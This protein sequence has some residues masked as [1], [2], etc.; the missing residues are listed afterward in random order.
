MK[1]NFILLPEFE[2]LKSDF[3]KCILN[4][5]STGEIVALGKR[6][7]I[8]KVKIGNET[9]TIKQFKKPIFF[10]SLV[11]RFIRKTKARRSFNY[12]NTLISS[13]IKTPYP[14]GFYESYTIGLNKSY[15]ICKYVDYHFDFRDLIH[16]PRFENRDRILNEFA[17][18]TF[19]LHENNINF[20]DHSPGN[21]LIV[22][23][24]S[25]YDF[26]LIDLNRMRF[27]N[28]DFDKRMHNFRRLWIS[29]TMI[30]VLAKQYAILYHK[31]YEEVHDL[32]LKHS[33]SFQRKVNAKKLR[34]SGRKMKFKK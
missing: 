16:Q 24:E 2:H 10:Q 21:T 19:Q 9:Y 30:K 33:R 13:G 14:I 3:E 34:R 28:M 25:N 26:Y 7:E 22:K 8:R 4:F 11:Y 15:Y 6:N 31:S 32:M 20:L 1:E 18:F 5:S 12:A 29:K 27:E 17:N 23:K